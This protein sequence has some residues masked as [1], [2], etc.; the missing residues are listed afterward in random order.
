[1]YVSPNISPCQ[2]YCTVP[3]LTS[4]KNRNAF[5]LTPTTL[6]APR[7]T[8]ST[9]SLRTRPSAHYV[10]HVQK[11]GRRLSV[12]STVISKRSAAR[13]NKIAVRTCL[14]RCADAHRCNRTTMPC[15]RITCDTNNVASPSVAKTR[16]THSSIHRDPSQSMP[17]LQER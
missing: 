8:S 2:L 1:M 17:Q 3:F 9:T 15:T 5:G 13:P 14:R 10:H 6:R 11:L 12:L 16:R 4:A 7:I